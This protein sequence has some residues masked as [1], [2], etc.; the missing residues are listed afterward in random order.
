MLLLT[1]CLLLLPSWESVIVLCFVVRYFMSILVLISSWWG[2]ESWLLLV[3]CLPDVS[4]L[5]CGSSSRYHGFVCSLWLWY[6]VIILTDYFCGGHVL[7]RIIF[8]LVTFLPNS[9]EIIL[10]IGFREEDILSFMYR[11][12]FLTDQLVVAN[13]EGQPMTISAISF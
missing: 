12:I 11:Y 1:C 4:W 3:V 6:F 5:F 7:W 8:F 2:I 13:F 9:F 10:I